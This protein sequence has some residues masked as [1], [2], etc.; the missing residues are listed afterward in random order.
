MKIKQWQKL[1][2]KNYWKDDQKLLFKTY[3]D[4]KEMKRRK[5]YYSQEIGIGDNYLCEIDTFD[6]YKYSTSLGAIPYCQRSEWGNWLITVPKFGQLTDDDIYKAIGYVLRQINSF[7]L[8]NIYLNK[9]HI[10]IL[11]FHNYEKNSETLREFKGM[12]INDEN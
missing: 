12:G 6:S 3:L 4:T 1:L 10:P 7:W 2:E 9:K 11:K 8:W 5:Q